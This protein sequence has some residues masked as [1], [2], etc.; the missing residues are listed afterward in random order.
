MSSK[1]I[2]RLL[3]SVIQTKSSPARRAKKGTLGNSIRTVMANELFTKVTKKQPAQRC[4]EMNFE[5]D[6]EP[7]SSNEDGAWLPFSDLIILSKHHND[8]PKAS[9]SMDE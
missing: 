7:E 3:S 4:L 5:C 1:S 6:I 2:I 9:D 8:T